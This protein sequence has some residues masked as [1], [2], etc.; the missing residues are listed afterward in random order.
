M[1][2]WTGKYGAEKIGTE[3]LHHTSGADDVLCPF[4]R[5]HNRDKIRCQDILP[6]TMFITTQ[7]KDKTEK[8]FHQATYC[9]GQYKK[10]W[11]YWLAMKAQWEDDED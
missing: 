6:G 11:L 9:E 5:A 1:A 10:C 8:Q 7:F 2:S 3:K 4:W